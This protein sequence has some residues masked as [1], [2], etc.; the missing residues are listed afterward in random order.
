MAAPS[1]RVT[2]N[3]DALQRIN[4]L[5]NPQLERPLGCT[6]PDSRPG[7]NANGNPE[8]AHKA[9]QQAH[10]DGRKDSQAPKAAQNK[11][12]VL[13]GPALLCETLQSG[14]MGDEGLEPPTSTV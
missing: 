10:A 14:A 7:D 5:V 6:D 9:A 12:P 2:Y 13:L 8:V 4:S 11:A 3:Y 1:G